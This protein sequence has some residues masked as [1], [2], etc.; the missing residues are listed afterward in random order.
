MLS[1]SD[2]TGQ[3]KKRKK[4]KTHFLFMKTYRKYLGMGKT[5]ILNIYLNLP[6]QLKFGYINK[7]IYTQAT[8]LC[9]YMKPSYTG[10]QN[11]TIKLTI[12]TETMQSNLNNGKSY[13]C[14]VTFKNFCQNLKVLSVIFVQGNKNDDHEDQMKGHSQ[15]NPKTPMFIHSLI[16]ASRV[17]DTGL[18]H[19]KE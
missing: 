2:Y 10:P 16:C 8:V 7:T 13:N 15:L 3:K 5:Q 1:I 19:H 18:R 6:R 12:Q 11:R 9:M 14:S 17:P 4:K